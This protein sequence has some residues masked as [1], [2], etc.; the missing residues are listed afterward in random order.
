MYVKSDNTNVYCYKILHPSEMKDNRLSTKQLQPIVDYT[1]DAHGQQLYIFKTP[2]YTIHNYKKIFVGHDTEWNN[3]SIE[4]RLFGYGNTILVVDQQ[5]KVYFIQDKVIRLHH[6]NGT[7]R[8]YISPV[9]NNDVP[10][11][12]I[13]ATTHL[14]DWCEEFAEH[15]IPQKEETAIRELCKIKHPP[16]QPVRLKQKI[17]RFISRYECSNVGKKY[18]T[19]QTVLYD[20]YAR[21]TDRILD[22][23]F[24]VYIYIYIVYLILSIY[25]RFVSHLLKK[26]YSQLETVDTFVFRV[27]FFFEIYNNN[28]NNNN[29]NKI[30]WCNTIQTVRTPIGSIYRQRILFTWVV[31]HN[32]NQNHT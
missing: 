19:V 12:M 6:I 24:V 7:V 21:V 23:L 8:G 9:G 1:D 13:F 11:P 3:T 25:L 4:N 20:T 28:N 5:T 16:H 17:T 31:N 32:Q 22:K 30:Y 2:Q 15:A 27:G 29:N 14:Y 10:Y 26:K 18:P